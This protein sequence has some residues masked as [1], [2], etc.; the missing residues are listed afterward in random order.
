VKAEILA[1][2]MSMAKLLLI[3]PPAEF[4]PS[5][6]NSASERSRRLQGGHLSLFLFLIFRVRLWSDV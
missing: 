1:P 6:W 5:P 3:L 2:L 4:Y